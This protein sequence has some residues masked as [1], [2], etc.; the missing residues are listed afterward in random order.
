MKVTVSNIPEIKIKYPC[1]MRLKYAK[2]LLIVL[3]K[4]DK[5]GTT[6]IPY[7][8]YEIGHYSEEWEMEDFIPLT[9][10]ITI[11]ND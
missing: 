2:G 6:I 9:E 7:K 1:L 10:T 5:C 11:Q 8:E 3:F 4:C